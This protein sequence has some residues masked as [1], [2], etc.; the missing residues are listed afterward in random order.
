[1]GVI[2]RLGA[3]GR[4]VLAYLADGRWSDQRL[5]KIGRRVIGIEFPESTIVALSSESGGPLIYYRDEG[6]R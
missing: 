4:T 2:V 3:S 5:Y 6:G 1:M